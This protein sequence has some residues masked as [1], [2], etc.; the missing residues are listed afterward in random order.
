M[1]DG[2]TIPHNAGRMLPPMADSPRCLA[3]GET[4]IWTLPAFTG[5]K[6][7]A[8]NE[9]GTQLPSTGNQVEHIK[10]IDAVLDRIT[11]SPPVSI[12]ARGGRRD[13]ALYANPPPPPLPAGFWPGSAGP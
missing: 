8:V 3:P 7:E 1:G 11:T 5:G 2:A 4:A 13:R 6:E 10:Q 9:S 12:W